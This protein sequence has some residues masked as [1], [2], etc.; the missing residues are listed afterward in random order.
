MTIHDP[1]RHQPSLLEVF[2]DFKFKTPAAARTHY[3]AAM[4]TVVCKALNLTQIPI[5]GKFAINFDAKCGLGKKK[6]FYEIK[7]V[8][9]LPS[10]KSV[11]YDWRMKKE[12]PY[13][14]RLSYV[15]LPPQSQSCYQ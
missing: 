8:R 1:K 15:F 12:K 6:E 13:Q 7:S 4:E 3:G 14:P 2:P 9:D 10:S 11:I 5:N